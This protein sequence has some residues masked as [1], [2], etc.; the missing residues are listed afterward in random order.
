M[1]EEL[2]G[3]ALNKAEYFSSSSASWLSLA[4]FGLGRKNPQYTSFNRAGC[5]ILGLPFP[6][7]TFIRSAIQNDREVVQFH[8]YRITL[9]SSFLLVLDSVLPALSFS[10]HRKA[11]ALTK[12]NPFSDISSDDSFFRIDQNNMPSIL[13]FWETTDWPTVFPPFIIIIR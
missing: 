13:I 9:I 10:R 2:D 4:L 8:I 5:I 12:I 7:L 3:P 6:V 11:S 1:E